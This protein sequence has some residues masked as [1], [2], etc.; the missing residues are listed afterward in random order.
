MTPNKA[1]IKVNGEEKQVTLDEIHKGDIVISKP[2]EK[3][4]VDGEILEGTAH[5]DESF[6]TGESKPSNKNKRR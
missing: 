5:F 2:G 4:A 1:T 6:I 3:I